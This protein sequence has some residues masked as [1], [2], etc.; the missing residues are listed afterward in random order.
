MERIVNRF[1]DLMEEDP[2]YARLRALHAADL[3]P[4][5]RS[6][7]GFLTGWAGDP[8][9]WFEENPDKC[10]MSMHAAFPI[11]RDTAGQWADAMERA[12]NECDPEDHDVARLISERLGTIARAM[13][14][15]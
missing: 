8:R 15:N 5:R 6:L 7:A 11:D 3:S 10:M 2:A 14:R 4:M 9:D 13:A 12:I 1:Y